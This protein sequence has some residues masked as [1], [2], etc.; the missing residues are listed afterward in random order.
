MAMVHR[1]HTLIQHGMHIWVEREACTP[2]RT[3]CSCMQTLNVHVIRIRTQLLKAIQTDSS[4]EGLRYVLGLTLTIFCQMNPLLSLLILD[5]LVGGPARSP[6]LRA[7]GS[8]INV[9]NIDPLIN[10]TPSS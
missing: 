2:H 1:T 4:L 5:G 7:N 3:A 10:A 6:T 9:L 8:S